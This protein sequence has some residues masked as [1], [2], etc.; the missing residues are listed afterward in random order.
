MRHARLL[1]NLER[2][3]PKVMAMLSKF[4]G[5][6][7]KKVPRLA[8]QLREY[9]SK[10]PPLI[11]QPASI[12]DDLTLGYAI[13][14][15]DGFI[16]LNVD[17]MMALKIIENEMKLNQDVVFRLIQHYFK[18]PEEGE[19]PESIYNLVKEYQR[20]REI[21]PKFIFDSIT[22]SVTGLT[23][24]QQ[25]ALVLLLSAPKVQFLKIR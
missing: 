17:P 14:A 12:A 9:V 16:D 20:Q 15:M 2:D 21:T 24:M 10:L 6:E 19:L 11:Q 8:D 7:L 18:T 1:I 22:G 3:V 5:D 25:K 23:Y 13:Q 4:F